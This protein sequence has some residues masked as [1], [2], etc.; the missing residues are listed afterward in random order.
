MFSESARAETLANDAPPSTDV[1]VPAVSSR[2][3][4]VSKAIRRYEKG[5]FEEWKETVNAKA[6]TLLKQP[7]FKA[8]EDSKPPNAIHVNF[9]PA[10]VV[11]IRESKYLDRMGFAVPETALNVTLQE[12]KYHDN[13][14]SLNEMLAAHRAVLDSLS[15]VEAELLRD[16]IADLRA[17]LNKGFLLLNW[18]SL[19]IPEFTDSCMKAINNFLTIVKQIQKNASIV[20]SV[21]EAIAGAELLRRPSHANGE[22]SEITELSPCTFPVPSLYLP[23]TFPHRYPRSRS[24]TTSSSG[25]G[26]PSST[27]SSGSTSRDHGSLVISARLTCDLGEV[28]L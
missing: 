2:F 28:D 25:T 12:D 9:D 13:V 3:V 18:N 11:L 14:E 8:A 27:S 21:V 26:S 1:T 24:S 16:R 5:K 20:K 22:V 23:C 19:S 10:L 4:A 15:P 6:M 17:S 7:I